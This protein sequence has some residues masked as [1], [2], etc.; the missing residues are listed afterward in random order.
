MRPVL[1]SE[2][3]ISCVSGMV[4]EQ[5]ITS[6]DEAMQQKGTVLATVPLSMFCPENNATVPSSIKQPMEEVPTA[7]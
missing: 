7:N 3:M 6:L 5:T 1:V 4:S 2:V